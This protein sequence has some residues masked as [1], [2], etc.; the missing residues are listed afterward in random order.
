[1]A[2]DLAN[3]SVNELTTFGVCEGQAI[4]NVWWV[5]TRTN[6]TS[7]FPIVDGS[8]PLIERLQAL[9]QT[10]LMSHLSEDFSIYLYRARLLDETAGPH[11]KVEFTNQDEVIGDV[12]L[13]VGG[14]TGPSFPTYTTVNASMRTGVTGRSKRGRK[15]FG[16]VPLSSQDTSGETENRISVAEQL[17]FQTDLDL[18]FLTLTVG[19]GATGFLADIGVFSPKLYKPNISVYFARLTSWRVQRMLGTQNSRKQ[20]NTPH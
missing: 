18:N 19:T 15:G 13:D 20:R 17:S 9:Q 14:A 6:G 3:N 1:M 2:Y 10:V 4:N 12:A 8:T 16:V 5:R 7:V 11:T